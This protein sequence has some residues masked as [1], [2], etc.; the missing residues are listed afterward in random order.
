MIWAFYHVVNFNIT[1]NWMEILCNNEIIMII[2]CNIIVWAS[3]LSA[4]LFIYMQ[5]LVKIMANDM[6]APPPLLQFD[7]SL[8]EILVLPPGFFTN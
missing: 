6:L 2:F 5:F 1:E 7:A 4:I 8:W 3:S